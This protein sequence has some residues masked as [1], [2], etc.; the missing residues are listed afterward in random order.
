MPPG[1][2]LLPETPESQGHLKGKVWVPAGPGTPGTMP[3]LSSGGAVGS[4]GSLVGPSPLTGVR[5]GRT[6][7]P[8]PPKLGSGSRSAG[9]TGK[10]GPQPRGWAGP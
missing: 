5:G 4:R 3:A 1:K 2:P 10:S 7:Y 6:Q 8:K 9:V